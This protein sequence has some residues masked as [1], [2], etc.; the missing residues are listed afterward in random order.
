MEWQQLL[1]DFFERVSQGL[2]KALA[3]VSQADLNDQPHLDCK[4]MGWLTWHL[5]RVQDKNIADLTGEQQVWMKDEW[6]TRFNRAPHPSYTG[7]GH[8]VKD[9]AAFRSPDVATL[10]EYHRAVLERSK[11]Y[12][13]SLTPTELGRE[14][15]H[16]LFHTVGARLVA[17]LND[18]IQHVGQVDYLRSLLKGESK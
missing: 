14:V 7:A 10:L 6:Y 16:P 3:N 18:N 9:V 17:L 13:V 2:E 8:K 5:T 15:D 12:L 4:S 1:I 11:Q